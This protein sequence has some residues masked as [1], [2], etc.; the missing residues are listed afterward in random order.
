MGSGVMCYSAATNFKRAYIKYGKAI[1]EER[2]PPMIPASIVLPI[3]MF[4][5]RCIPWIHFFTFDD[6]N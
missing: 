5:V 6:M 1:P 4:W 3:A 2:L